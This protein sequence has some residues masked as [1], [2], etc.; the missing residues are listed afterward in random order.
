VK[1]ASTP[2]PF[3]TSHAHT[4]LA[5]LVP[6]L[7]ACQVARG[8]AWSVKVTYTPDGH[9]ASALPTGKHPAAQTAC[10]SGQLKKATIAPFAGSPTPYVFDFVAGSK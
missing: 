6:K 10:V 4:A 2:K 8:S 9:V 3:D 1:S 5:A 7:S